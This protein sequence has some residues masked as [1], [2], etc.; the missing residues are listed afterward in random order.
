[1]ILST[2]AQM[3][4]IIGIYA[5]QN[6]VDLRVQVQADKFCRWYGV[7]EQGEQGEVMWRGGP[8]QLCDG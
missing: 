4:R 2:G 3:M 5:D 1:V 6:L 8:A 7:T